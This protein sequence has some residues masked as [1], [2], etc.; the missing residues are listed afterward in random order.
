MTAGAGRAIEP[1]VARFTGRFR[2]TYTLRAPLEAARAHFADLDA[3]IANYGVTRYD[4]HYTCTWETDGDRVRWRTIDRSTL[5]SSGSATFEAL[6]DG[7]TRMVYE[8]TLALEID[9]GRLLSAVIGKIVEA[10][11]AKEARAYVDRLV[12][13]LERRVAA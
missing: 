5:D 6:P 7:R 12:V 1:R 11:I 3:V 2:E 8:I 13:A 10:A 9:V 4:G